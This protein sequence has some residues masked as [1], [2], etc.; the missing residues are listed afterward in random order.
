MKNL[1][2]LLMMCVIGLFASC[3]DEKVKDKN[4][5][6]EVSKNESNITK[7]VVQ[8]DVEKLKLL[9]RDNN[10]FAFKLFAEMKKS[11]QKNILISPFSL[12]EALAMTYLGSQD[13]TKSE[14]SRV[15]NFNGDDKSFH[16]G[17]NALDTVLNKS[18]ADNTL[19][20]NNALWFD[21]SYEVNE[22]FT[23]DLQKN[24]GNTLKS[25]DFKNQ[26]QSSITEINT[27]IEKN[28]NG[29]LKNTLNKN[30]ID[31]NMQLILTNV[32]YFKANWMNEFY[33][34]ATTK[35]KFYA[36]NGTV[37]DVSML[38]NEY[39]ML[40]AQNK[41]FQSVTL[42]Y[43]GGDSSMVILLPKQ[44]RFEKVMKNLKSNYQLANELSK[45]ELVNL[46]LPKMK[47]STPTYDMKTYFE[48]M[49]LVSPFS[50]NAN[51]SLIGSQPLKIDTIKHK[52]FIE[53]DEKGTEASAVTVILEANA[54]EAN[55]TESIPKKMHINRDFIFFIKNNQTSQILFMGLIKEIV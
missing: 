9:A 4:V 43:I 34:E 3:A 38:N 35:E 12:S 14:I 21:K 36:L 50:E 19:K 2:V 8:V 39:E 45:L 47:F 6:F 10:D 20:T 18:S 48:D 25:M 51:F 42:D 27:W 13:D 30:G 28:S 26:L 54:T 24:Y 44:G 32:I 40:Y 1:Q 52:A 33:V 16:S 29:T 37:Q 17:F 53:I 11:E 5:T 41:D 23:K 49:G 46:K 22:S 7:E 55:I 31:K 15:M